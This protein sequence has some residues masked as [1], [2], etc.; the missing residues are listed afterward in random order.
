[1]VR[2]ALGSFVTRGGKSGVCQLQ[3]RVVRDGET[4]IVAETR[5]LTVSQIALDDLG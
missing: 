4:P 5:G 1:M 2:F 3:G